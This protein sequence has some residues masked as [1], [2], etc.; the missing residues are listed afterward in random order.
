M[1]EG[2]KD[3]DGKVAFVTGGASGIGLALA[4]ALAAAGASVTIADV[5]QAALDAAVEQL[6]ETSRNVRGVVCDVSD[7]NAV[8]A[9]AD[10]MFSKPG[11]VHVLCNNAGV[12]V[13]GLTEETAAHDWQWLISVNLMGVVHGLQAF[14]PRMKRQGEGGYI[15]NTASGAGLMNPG[16]ISAYSATKFAVVGISEGLSAELAGTGIGV[17][18]LCPSYV[19]TNIA[20][21]ARNRPTRF[22]GAPELAPDDPVNPM[23]T[24]VE[25]LRTGL[26]PEVVAARTLEAVAEGQLYVFT[27]PDMRG[28]ID[29]RDARIEAGFESADRSVALK[30]GR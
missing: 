15:I 22:G 23:S 20:S 30:T 21:S 1:G 12:S 13:I 17:S 9:A 19:A 6:R 8:H 27:H 26:S 3:F 25:L 5:E 11:K 28:A 18:V 2:M 16:M 14:L 10:R 24:Q 29:E 4:R 7:A